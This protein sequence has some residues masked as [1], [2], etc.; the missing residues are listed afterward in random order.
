MEDGFDT[1]FLVIPNYEGRILL[2]LSPEIEEHHSVVFVDVD[3]PVAI[4]C[5]PVGLN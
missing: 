4:F 3:L 2:L 1:T 5:I